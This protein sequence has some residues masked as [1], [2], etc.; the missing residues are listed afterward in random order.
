[1]YIE[2]ITVQRRQVSQKGNVILLLSFECKLKDF[3]DMYFLKKIVYV[4]CHKHQET[5][6]CAKDPLPCLTYSMCHL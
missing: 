2:T 6:E 1:M 4:F 3:T 5:E